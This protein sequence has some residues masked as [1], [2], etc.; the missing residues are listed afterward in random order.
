MRRNAGEELAKLVQNEE[1]QGKG[2]RSRGVR[3]ISRRR[4]IIA[5][6]TDKGL[7]CGIRV[8]W[9]EMDEKLRVETNVRKLTWDAFN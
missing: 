6:G 1:G 9:S 8:E 3:M 5:G 2:R 4:R 7:E